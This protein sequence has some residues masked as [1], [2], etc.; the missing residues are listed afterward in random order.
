MLDRPAPAAVV[1]WQRGWGGGVRGA[2]G[3]D[4]LELPPAE[5]KGQCMLGYTT[6]TKGRPEARLCTVCVGQAREV[7]ESQVW[8]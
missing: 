8:T 7:G 4:R 3:A 5:R 1:I 6:E 2:D